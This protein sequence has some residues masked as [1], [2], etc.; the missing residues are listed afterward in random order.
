MVD[1]NEAPIEDKSMR[2]LRVLA[3]LHVG[4]AVCTIGA[5]IRWFLIL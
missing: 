2:A 3:V 1:Y 4:A 5:S